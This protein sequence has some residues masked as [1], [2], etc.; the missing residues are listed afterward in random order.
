MANLLKTLTILKI[1]FF[2]SCCGMKK[3]IIIVIMLIGWLSGIGQS[4]CYII[5]GNYSGKADLY[6]TT[7]F[8]TVCAFI[9]T[10]DN[11]MGRS[12]AASK[13]VV[14]G[15]FKVISYDL[16]TV[17]TYMDEDMSLSSQAQVTK[18]E[19]EAEGYTEYLSV[20]KEIG[21]GSINYKVILELPKTG[22]FAPVRRR[23]HLRRSVAMAAP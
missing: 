22:I 20:V 10:V 3:L 15:S 17:S 18:E 16:H 11:V 7:L 14:S 6:T 13:G 19:I 5:K 8:D 1:I 21:N 12:S 2:S 4:D 9:E 23:L